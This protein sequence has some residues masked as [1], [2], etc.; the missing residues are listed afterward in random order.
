MNNINIYNK[1][2]K[3]WYFSNVFLGNTLLD[4]F[5]AIIIFAGT[6]VIFK[7]IIKK[8]FSVIKKIANKTTTTIDNQIINYFEQKKKSSFIPIE[9][10]FSLLIS[11]QFI[12]CSENIINIVGNITTIILTIYVASIIIDY[13]KYL[14]HS[15]YHSN[16]NDPKATTFYLLLPI[17]KIFIWILAILFIMSNLG[18]DITTLLAGLGIGGIAIALASQAFLSDLLS[19]VSIVSD[20][21]FEIGDYILVNG[22]EGSVKK[23]GIKSVRIEGNTGEEI[24]L[25]NSKITSSELHNFRRMN[26]RKAELAFEVQAQTTSEQLKLIPEIIQKICDEKAELEFIRCHFS[27]FSSYAFEVSA[28]YFVL[29]SDF[30]V[31]ANAREY[32]NYRVLEELDLLGIKLA[33][34]KQDI[35]LFPQKL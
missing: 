23:I 30:M 17:I 8:G 7:F 34:P 6:F 18:R 21:P 26:K 3:M 14:I 29:D 28:V 11:M 2:E 13:I 32:L 24:V 16:N 1:I 19:F 15:K 35:R 22:I 25:P 27:G 20:K 33:Y 9:L 31:F 5:I 10:L 4:Y 12:N